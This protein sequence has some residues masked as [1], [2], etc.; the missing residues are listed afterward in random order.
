MSAAAFLPKDSPYAPSAPN[1][2]KFEHTTPK[3]FESSLSLRSFEENNLVSTFAV[4]PLPR[5][6]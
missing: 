2:L 4:L 5:P 3:L 6:A 1:S